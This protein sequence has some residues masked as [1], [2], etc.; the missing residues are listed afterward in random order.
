MKKR[1]AIL[2][3]ISK[4]LGMGHL[5]RMAHL[6]VFLQNTFEIQFFVHTKENSVPFLDDKRLR[7]RIV[8]DNEQETLIRSFDPHAIFIDKR[9]TLNKD[10]RKLRRISKILTFDNAGETAYADC[11]INALPLPKEPCIISN[12]SGKDYLIFNENIVKF[13]KI[14]SPSRVNNV[15][16]SFGGSDPANLSKYV[17]NIFRELDFDINVK[18]VVGPLHENNH[19]FSPY[20]TIVTNNLP[21]EISKTDLLI[22]S[23]GM[24]AYEAILIGTLPV[25]INPTEYHNKLA[26]T[27][28]HAVNL[29]VGGQEKDIDRIKAG[30]VSLIENPDTLKNQ[31]KLS[32]R[33]LD[34]NGKERI[35]DITNE[36]LK[37]SDPECSVCGKAYMPV[38]HRLEKSNVYFCENC[39]TLFRDKD[40][41][42]STD[43]D[44]DYFFNDYKKQYGKTYLEDKQNINKLNEKRVEIINELVTTKRPVKPLLELGCAMGFFLETVKN[45]G[46]KPSGIEISRHAAS[47]CKY[48]AKLD[49]EQG[50]FLNLDY[51]RPVYEVIS[52]WYFIEHVKD[53]K[54]VIEKCRKVLRDRGI[55]AISTPNC[56]GISARKNITSYASRIPGDHYNEFSPESLTKVFNENGFKVEKIVS[57]GVHFSRWLDGRKNILLDNKIGESIY[58]KLAAKKNLGDT[59]EIYARKVSPSEI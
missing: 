53:F 12:Y 8:N 44:A 37:K 2:T 54:K 28:E 40:Y 7:Y 20:E 18:F 10:L 21:E 45:H 25:L 15:L 48:T 17:Y 56:N 32:R 22:T 39:K 38:V 13:K 55:I 4:N 33:Y 29:G 41:L 27:L 31:F 3:G 50:D 5:T 30:I 1:I 19:D 43:Y 16:I 9:D 34:N 11:L 52:M 59:F 46:Y 36:L 47:Y 49:V 58:K 42:V 57:T 23:F 14:Y 35:K 6:A 51:S 26:Q 24:T